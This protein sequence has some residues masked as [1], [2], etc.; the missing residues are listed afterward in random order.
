MGPARDTPTSMTLIGRLQNPCTDEGAWSE[1]VDR[2]GPK[3][4]GWCRKWT[5]NAADVEDVTQIVLLRLLRYLRTFRYNSRTSFRGWL[6]TVTDNA[7]LDFCRL[8]TRAVPG[9][10][11][12]AVQDQL[13]SLAAREDLVHKLE[14]A[15]DL[16]LLEEA[17]ARVRLRVKRERWEAYQLLDVE[18]L[19]GA[20]VA[21]RLGMQLAAVY[22]ACSSV[23]KMLREEVQL[24]ENPDQRPKVIS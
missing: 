14:G 12:S 23:R 15:F 11:D 5:A 4:H 8:R 22:V 18:R 17:S 16:E 1:F 13:E 20:E 24:L 2:Y 9:S 21:G 19:S 3:I 10:G 6:R 7:W